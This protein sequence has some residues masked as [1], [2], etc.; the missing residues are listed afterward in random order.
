MKNKEDIFLIGLIVIIIILVVALFTTP[1]RVARDEE[2][3]AAVEA[4]AG[5]NIA[6][7]PREAIPEPVDLGTEEEPLAAE[8]DEPAEEAEV[9]E[10]IKET[11]ITINNMKFSTTD[12][13]IESGE[14]VTWI[15]RD[16]YDTYQIDLVVFSRHS[17]SP[18]ISP[19]ESWSIELTGPTVYYFNAVG[20]SDN[21]KGRIRVDGP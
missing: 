17:Y 14:R 15:N 18:K 12:V 7:P 2:T 3:S 8:A 1:A 6:A 13:E 4:V 19:G 9:E 5:V 16:D 11:E 21:K 10:P 20:F